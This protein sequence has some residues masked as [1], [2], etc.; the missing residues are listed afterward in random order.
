MLRICG[1]NQSFRSL[2]IRYAIHYEEMINFFH[3]LKRDGPSVWNEPKK[4]KANYK[5]LLGK[6]KGK[7]TK[8]IGQDLHKF[9]TNSC[10]TSSDVTCPKVSDVGSFTNL[11]S[12]KD[13]L[14]SGYQSLK[15]V[16]PAHSPHRL[17]MAI[18]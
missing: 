4:P 2:K 11:A 8:L 9:L 17:T 15:N 16:I 14:I 5:L 12:M 1:A 18:G 7:F 13:Y 3:N 6:Q 10:I